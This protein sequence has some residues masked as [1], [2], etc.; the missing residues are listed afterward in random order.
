MH[1]NITFQKTLLTYNL[2]KLKNS[3]Q[4]S[5]PLT[6]IKLFV[7]VKEKFLHLKLPPG[8]WVGYLSVGVQ[9]RY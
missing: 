8:N 3:F 4:I 7:L 1:L 9:K 2:K 5:A 6:E